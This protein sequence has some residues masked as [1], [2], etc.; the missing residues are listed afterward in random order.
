MNGLRRSRSPWLGRGGMRRRHDGRATGQRG[1]ALVLVLVLMVT[2]TILAGAAVLV[3]TRYHD[4][5]AREAEK[6]T[7]ETINRVLRREVMDTAAIPRPADLLRTVATGSG[8]SVVQAE[9]NRRGNARVVLADPGL[10]LGPL[11][12]DVLPYTQTVMASVRPRNP[13]LLL[14]ASAGSPLPTDLVTGAVLEADQ[15]DSIWNTAQGQVPADWDWNGN[16]EDLCIQ[17]VDFGDLFVQLTL[18]YYENQPEHRGMYVLDSQEAPVNLPA[19]LPNEASSFAPFVIRGTCLSLYG[20]DGAVQLRDIIQ[21]NDAV[22]TCRDG[23]WYRGTG[24]LGNR[25]G[26]SIRH[27]TPEEFADALMAFLKPE[28]PVWSHNHATS[29]ADLEAAIINF[30]TAGAYDNQSSAMGQ[31]QQALIDA[32]VNFTGAAPNKP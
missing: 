9:V 22:Y 15:F 6:T 21:D 4:F 12:L 8:D 31:A 25:V 7:L 20:T 17:R 29:K 11:G 19:L 13:R 30:L 23:V 26:P 2:L 16:R 28:I 1:F 24:R 18:R 27:P 10:R 5:A 14:L 32:W 3:W